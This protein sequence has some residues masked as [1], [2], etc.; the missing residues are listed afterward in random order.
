MK[1]YTNEFY[2]ANK[3]MTR[4]SKTSL[5]NNYQST[6][7]RKVT[8]A[9]TPSNKFYKTKGIGR[10]NTTREITLPKTHYRNS[11]VSK[12]NIDFKMHKFE[13]KSSFYP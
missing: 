13:S 11:S 5:D 4:K 8:E 3:T 7:I 6:K 9:K 2:T 10:R 12:A 1:F